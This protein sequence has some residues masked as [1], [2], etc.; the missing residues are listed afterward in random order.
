VLARVPALAVDGRARQERRKAD[1]EGLTMRTVTLAAAAALLALAGCR[2]VASHAEQAA[3]A[4]ASHE[5][6]GEAQ[7]R[8]AAERRAEAR[9]E[10][11]EKIAE[12]GF[13]VVKGLAEADAEANRAAAGDGENR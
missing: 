12:K 11:G 8:I 9:K 7:I 4:A 13:H 6:T 1:G 10:R 5:T 2:Q 3:A